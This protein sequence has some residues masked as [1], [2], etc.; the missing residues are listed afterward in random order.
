[1]ARYG[2]L[3][4]DTLG[5]DT[6]QQPSNRNRRSAG[7]RRS[8]E[9]WHWLSWLQISCETLGK[10]VADVA[11]ALICTSVMWLPVALNVEGVKTTGSVDNCCLAVGLYCLHSPVFCWSSAFPFGT[12]RG[13]NCRTQGKTQQHIMMN[14]V[15]TLTVN[16]KEASKLAENGRCFATHVFW[17]DL[18]LLVDRRHLRLSIPS[19]HK[20]GKSVFNLVVCTYAVV[21]CQSTKVFATGKHG[22]GHAQVLLSDL[23]ILCIYTSCEPGSFTS[24]QYMP[25]D[26]TM[27]TS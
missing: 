22:D 25:I 3:N 4:P 13:W 17:G 1:M 19:M 2:K 24:L 5:Q 10:S 6:D 11:G 9:L 23:S 26:A 7:G 8:R 27:I 20:L 18:K 12:P 15:N 21:T 16:P 14:W